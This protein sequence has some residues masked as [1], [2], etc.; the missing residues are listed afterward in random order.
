M[1]L[2]V[3][4]Y[5]V[6]CEAVRAEERHKATILGF[7]NITP[8]VEIRLAEFG[9]GAV[10]LMFLFGT[11][12]GTG[13]ANFQVVILDPHGEVLTKSPELSIAFRE[14]FN[15]TNVGVGVPAITFREPGQHTLQLRVSGKEVFEG[16]F[17]M[18]LDP[19][20]KQ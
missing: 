16:T 13:K 1:P 2:P 17:N 9:V 10:P 11:T 6:V 14:G 4:N 19:S 18:L 5:C 15:Q 7:F 3:V 20:V 12:G 8:W